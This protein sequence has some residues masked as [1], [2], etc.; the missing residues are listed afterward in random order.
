MSPNN[1]ILLNG[2]LLSKLPNIPF[3]SCFFIS[4]DLFLP[5]PT[6]F[7]DSI[8]LPFLGFSTFER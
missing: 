4:L 2:V 6:Y 3:S 8:V 7:D 5:H 1:R